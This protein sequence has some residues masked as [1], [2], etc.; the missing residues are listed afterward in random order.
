MLETGAAVNPTLPVGFDLVFAVVAI[1]VVAL[2]IAA[3]VSI[4]R[5]RDDLGRPVTAVWMVA[6]VVLPIIASVAWFIFGLPKMNHT[7]QL[8]QS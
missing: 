4:Y 2:A 1:A 3:L 6:V 5:H 7:A 8:P